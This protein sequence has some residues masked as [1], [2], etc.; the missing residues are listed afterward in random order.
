LT[1]LPLAGR[2]DVKELARG[3]EERTMANKG[4]KKPELIVLVRGRPEEAVLK[5]CKYSG[6]SGPDDTGCTST[7]PSGKCNANNKS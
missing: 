5:T 2:L 4:W 3:R 1:D 6:Q 7:G